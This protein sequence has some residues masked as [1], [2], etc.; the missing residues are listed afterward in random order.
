MGMAKSTLNNDRN[1]I[2]NHMRCFY[3]FILLLPHSLQAQFSIAGTYDGYAALSKKGMSHLPFMVSHAKLGAYDIN[4]L[5]IELA[6]SKNQL[7]FQFSPAIG[8]YMQNNY[9]AEIPYR[10]L[11]YESYLQY[12]RGKSALAFGTF[13]SP[14]TQETPRA[15]DQ[16]SP[17]RSLAAEYVPYYVSGLRWSQQWTTKFRSQLFLTN[18]WQ[19]LAFSGVR[20]SLGLLLQWEF[21]KWKWNWSH[22][23]GDVSA[24]GKLSPEAGL[25]RWRFFQE[26][27]GSF[28]YNAWTFQ[29]CAYAGA[30]KRNGD[31]QLKWW[32][33]ANLQASYALN[34]KLSTF[35]RAE[36]FYDPEQVVFN[37]DAGAFGSVSVGWM[38]QL[39]S[40]LQVGQEFRYFRGKHSNIPVLYSFLRLKF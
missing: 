10:R 27:N 40:V 2:L 23:Y 28:Q 6:Y 25:N 13:S 9:A 4:L 38:Q 31:A 16:L 33:Q 18:G 29:S 1:I 5:E 17:S 26:F 34:P 7:K 36:V 3:L 35:S 24:M 21:K 14:Y 30:Q 39:G 37:H 15:V 12:E 32:G 11:M 20:P 19:R 22:F 8:S